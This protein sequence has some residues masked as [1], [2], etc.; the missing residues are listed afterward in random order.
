MQANP[1]AG[2]RV[3]ETVI[4]RFKPPHRLHKEAII[5]LES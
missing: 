4:T 5:T 1:Q 3:L 2:F